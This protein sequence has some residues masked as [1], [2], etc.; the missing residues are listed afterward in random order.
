LLLREFQ[1]SRTQ[2]KGHTICETPI[3][4]LIWNYCQ[5]EF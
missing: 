5:V 4:T 3:Q 1:V 2:L